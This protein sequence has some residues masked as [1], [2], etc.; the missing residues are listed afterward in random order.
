MVAKSLNNRWKKR[1]FV[2][3]VHELKSAVMQCKFVQ[4]TRIQCW[5]V[6]NELKIQYAKRKVHTYRESVPSELNIVCN[7]IACHRHCVAN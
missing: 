6:W 7:V 5:N 4:R 1:I 2:F 3:F